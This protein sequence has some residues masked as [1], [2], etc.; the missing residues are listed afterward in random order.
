MEPILHV[1]LIEDNA[2]EAFLLKESLAQVSHPPEVIHA[3]TLEGA[4]RHL[5]ESSVDAILLDLAL[6]DSEGLA[7]LDRANAAAD[8]LPIIVL[9]EWDFRTIAET[10]RCC[11]HKTDIEY[12]LCAF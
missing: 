11:E 1:L 10:G 3:D 7:T 8:Y 6:P 5:S 2:A 9:S 12:F 4:L